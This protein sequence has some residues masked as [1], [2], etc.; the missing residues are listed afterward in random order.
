MLIVEPRHRDDPD[1]VECGR[2]E[3]FTCK[4]EHV[5]EITVERVLAGLKLEDEPDKWFVRSAYVEIELIAHPEN[6]N[7][8]PFIFTKKGPNGFYKLSD[9]T[10]DFINKQFEGGRSVC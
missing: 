2:P 9:I 1:N 5:V 8:P 10:V 4:N 7:D 6:P 3:V